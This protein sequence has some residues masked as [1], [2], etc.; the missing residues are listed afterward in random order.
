RTGDSGVDAK[1]GRPHHAVGGADL[2]AVPG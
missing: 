2:L 1:M